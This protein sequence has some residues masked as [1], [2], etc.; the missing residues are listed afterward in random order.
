[1]S[2]NDLKDLHLGPPEP[3]SIPVD[4]VCRLEKEINNTYRI[5]ITLETGTLE[6]RVFDTKSMASHVFTAG[7]IM[8]QRSNSAVYEALRSQVSGMRLDL[9]RKRLGR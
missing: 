6:V 1:M 4:L 5:K 2:I 8:A 7:S 3:F 9:D